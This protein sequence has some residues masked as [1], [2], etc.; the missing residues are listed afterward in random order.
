MRRL[1]AFAAVLAFALPASAHHKKAKILP[2]GLSPAPA[3]VVVCDK[4]Q[5]CSVTNPQL[6]YQPDQAHANDSKLTVRIIGVRW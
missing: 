6:P 1:L 3:Q 4:K 5:H 2:P